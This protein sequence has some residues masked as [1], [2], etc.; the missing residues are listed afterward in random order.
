M[1]IDDD[2]EEY[3]IWVSVRVQHSITLT[4]EQI[5]K[6]FDVDKP[7]EVDE[8]AFEYYLEDLI[9]PWDVIAAEI[10]AWDY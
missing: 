2:R 3:Q 7:S 8:I 10:D 4:K 1:D 6:A 9:E 5:C